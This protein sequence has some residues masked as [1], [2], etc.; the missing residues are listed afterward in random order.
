MLKRL[1]AGLFEGGLAGVLVA[2]SLG[3]L[4]LSWGGP[5]VVYGAAA[6]LGLLTALVAGRPIWS[7]AAKT[8]VAIKSVAGAF[9]AVVS[10]F[11]A[12]KWLSDVTTDLS[13]IGAGAGRLG[14]LPRVVLPLIGMALAAVFEVD[15]AFGPGEGV[16]AIPGAGAGNQQTETPDAQGPEEQ[17]A[18]RESS[19]LRR[20]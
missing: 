20:D 6:T 2:V 11:G 10:M 4:H 15:D 9:I 5:P 18:P 13:S 1:V 19:R 12:R 8:E 17:A 7:K 16:R 14:D 3:W